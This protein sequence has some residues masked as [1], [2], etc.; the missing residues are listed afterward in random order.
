MKLK[1]YLRGFGIGILVST[2][3]LMISFFRHPRELSDKEIISRAQELG[4]VMGENKTGD[5]IPRATENEDATEQRVQSSEE[6]QAQPKAEGGDGDNTQ[7]P[8]NEKQDENDITSTEKT[9]EPKTAGTESQTPTETEENDAE[10]RVTEFT[11]ADGE[12]AFSVARRLGDEGLVDNWY[13]FITYLKEMDYVKYI[14]P[15]TVQ[16][17]E[18]ADYVKIGEILTQKR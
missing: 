12:S 3:I 16:I 4:M 6:S 2:I 9:E 11:V 10:V 7:L 17:P 13:A 15:G 14:L 1:Y 8:E 18:G 5:S